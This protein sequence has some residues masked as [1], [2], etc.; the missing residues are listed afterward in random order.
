M[1]TRIKAN[2]SYPRVTSF[3]GTPIRIRS[4][5]EPPEQF[6]NGRWRPIDLSFVRS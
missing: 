1:M 6:V 2:P 5:S 4:S 3:C